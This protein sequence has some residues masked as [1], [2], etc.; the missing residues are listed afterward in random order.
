MEKKLF[1]EM[2]ILDEIKKAVED[3]GFEEATAIQTQT[4]PL[5]MTGKDVIG[6]S[7]TG[8]GKTA[9]FGIPALQKIDIKNRKL[10]ILVLC[11][12]RELAIQA[13]EEIRKYAKHMHGIRTLP[14]YGG[15]PIERQIRALKGGVQI[16]IGTPGRVMDHMRRRTLRMDNIK[17]VVLDEADEMLNMGFREDM[18]T[19]LSDIPKERQ[20]VLFSATMSKEILRIT[21]NFQNEP[22]LVKVVHKQLTVSGIEQ[23]YLETKKSNKTD[24]LSKLIDLYDPKLSLVFCNTKRMVDELV[25]DLQAM[26]YMVDGIHG[27]IKQV[28]RSKVMNSFRQG[29]I[30]ILV[31]TDVAARGIDVDDVEAVFNYDLPQDEEYYVHRIGRTARAGRTG[32]S[33]TFISG[34]KQFYSLRDIERYANTKV[35]YHKVPTARAVEAN[36]VNKFIDDVKEIIKAGELDKQNSI[37]DKLMEDDYTS[38]EI[39]AALVKMHFKDKAE[40]SESFESFKKL[41]TGSEE[42]MVRL[43]MNIGRID[44][45][46]PGDIVGAIAGETG[47][48]GKVI[49]SIDIYDKYTFVEV[50]KEVTSDVLKAMKKVEIRGRKINIEPAKPKR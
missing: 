15:Q 22:E 2:E 5:I 47:I 23:F 33:F 34:K 28:T 43:F 35:K 7:Q 10:Q 14:I 16:V 39:A 4:I 46:S 37:I 48:H 8:T 21:K 45:V 50:P 25:S 3:M 42:G 12:T 17:L 44:K 20:T 9:A 1:K 26:G 32:K 19:I 11:P 30:D 41:D 27:D 38:F 24:V 49:G 36:K 31:A 40:S 29:I 18:E 6:H 13:S